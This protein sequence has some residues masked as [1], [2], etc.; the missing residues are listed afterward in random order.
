MAGQF[1]ADEDRLLSDRPVDLERLLGNLST[2]G[3]GRHDLDERDE[4]GGIERVADDDAFG[5]GGGMSGDLRGSVP[6]RRRGD[7]RGP[8]DRGIDLGQQGLVDL[9]AF[10]TV[11]LDEV[12]TG[13]R[14]G[15]AVGAP[16]T[17]GGRRLPAIHH[18]EVVLHLLAQTLLGAGRRVER[19]DRVTGGEESGGPGGTDDPGA[20]DRDVQR[21]RWRGHTP[22]PSFD[23]AAARRRAKSTYS[24]SEAGSCSAPVL[25]TSS[26]LAPWMMRLTG[27]S[28]FLP[29]RPNGIRPTGT[30]SS[31]ACRGDRRDLSALRIRTPR[32]SVKATS[33]SVRTKTMSSPIPPSSSSRWMTR[34]SETSGS[35]SSTE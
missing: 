18:G 23:C 7:D 4:M 15:E 25:A 17:I 33:S 1:S 9:E 31:G 21:C 29:V 16:E 14:L 32:S 28:S 11:L 22:A 13:D 10:G 2:G 20:D 27:T 5:R 35:V 34:P 30:I 6:G 24:S 3:W 8:R 26:A 19:R 12:G